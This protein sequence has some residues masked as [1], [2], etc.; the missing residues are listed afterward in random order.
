MFI[1]IYK[2]LFI[3]MKI[4]LF[5]SNGMLGNYLKSYLSKFC[6]YCIDRNIFDIETC[7]WNELDNIIKNNTNKN[8]IIINCAGAIPQNNTDIKKFIILNTLFPHKLN[9]ISKK[10]E[11]K[12]IHITTDCVYDGSKG[13]YC[14]T[15]K[16]TAK[17]IYGITKSLGEPDYA[18]IIR[19][20]IIGEELNN[21][22]SLIEW[23]KSNKN[24]IINGYTNHYWNGVTCLEL[25]KYIKN[26]IDTNELWIGIK[27]VFSP[28]IITKYDLCCYVNEIYNLQIQINKCEDINNKNMTLCGNSYIIKDIYTQ[29]IEQKNFE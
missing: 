21:K 3:K 15:D 13:K 25:A 1:K 11:L 12:F 27:H 24:G 7:N 23:I 6:L 16:H 9:D 14:I 18:T 28:E 20:S 26:I 17:N 8:D 29:I 19:T 5:G 2:F 4:L 22:K 10:Y